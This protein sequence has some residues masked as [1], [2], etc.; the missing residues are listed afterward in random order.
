MNIDY[1]Q[2]GKR[3]KLKR[4]ENRF[5]QEQ[6]AEKLEVSVGYISQLERGITKIN[7]DTLAMISN[8]LKCD[9]SYFVSKNSV[10]GEEYL[11]DEFFE[12]FQK[13][14]AEQRAI[15]VDIMKILIAH[16]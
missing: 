16:S 5:T 8:I 10:V 15:V 4:K 14:S 7:L 1:K 6:L 9:I 2:I 3:I 11:C 13:L 12:K